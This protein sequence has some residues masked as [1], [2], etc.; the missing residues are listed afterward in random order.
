MKINK[1]IQ[2]E[3]SAS[4]FW[5]GIS[6]FSLTIMIVFAHLLRQFVLSVKQIKTKKPAANMILKFRPLF[7]FTTNKK[8]T[9]FIIDLPRDHFSDS[10]CWHS[11][12]LMLAEYPWQKQIKKMQLSLSYFGMAT[13]RDIIVL[14]A[15]ITVLQVYYKRRIKK[16]RRKCQRSSFLFGRKTLFNSLPR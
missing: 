5:L 7:K 6:L 8:T 16:D 3:F 13:A 9:T 1:Y 12:W 2:V 11:H 4:R 15:I 14:K 10:A